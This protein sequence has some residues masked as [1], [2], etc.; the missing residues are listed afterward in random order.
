MKLLQRAEK[1]KGQ[2]LTACNRWQGKRDSNNSARIMAAL[3]DN[4][5]REKQRSIIIFL[6]SG[7]KLSE[8]DR[9]MIQQYGGSCISER[10]MYQWVERF[11]EDR[12]SVVDEHRSGRPC[13]AGYGR[14]NS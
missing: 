4:C 10:K 1:S 8:I 13:T 6:W 9:R 2:V 14:T 7:V 11:Q 3:L 5:T 12:T